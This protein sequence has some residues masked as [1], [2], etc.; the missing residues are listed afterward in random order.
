MN[1]HKEPN[2][3]STYTGFVKNIAESMAEI[4]NIS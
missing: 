3:T 2:G 4:L 1:E